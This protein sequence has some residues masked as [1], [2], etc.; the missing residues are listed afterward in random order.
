MGVALAFWAVGQGAATPSVTAMISHQAGPAEQ[1]RVLAAS[2]SLSALARV[3]GPW[4]GGVAL[5]HV[6]MSAP[7]VSAS[8]L[9]C[10][11]LAV[12]ALTGVVAVAR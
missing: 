11:A 3:L 1:G 6:G 4:W 9:V 10:A 2:Q 5:A 7:Y 12:L 8:L